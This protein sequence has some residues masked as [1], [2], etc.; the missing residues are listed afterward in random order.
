MVDK[1]LDTPIYWEEA[2]GNTTLR[3]SLKLLLTTLIREA[4]NFSGKRPLGNS[5]WQWTLGGAL[6]KVGLLP[7]TVDSSDGFDEIDFD[8]KD[9]D[10]L[11]IEAIKKL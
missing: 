5:D 9:F 6:V 3:E 10:N 7:G 2:D 1:V 4:E 8:F 11:I